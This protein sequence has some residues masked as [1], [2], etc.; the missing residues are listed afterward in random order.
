MCT[1]DSKESVEISS[2]IKFDALIPGGLH[3]LLHCLLYRL[4]C[5]TYLLSSLNQ[6]LTPGAY[7]LR[8]KY[9]CQPGSSTSITQYWG[10]ADSL[11]IMLNGIEHVN[12]KSKEM[13]WAR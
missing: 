1:T 7:M 4:Y 5:A 6:Y 13:L 8:I 3:C 9:I 11:R 10:Y 2:D 12:L